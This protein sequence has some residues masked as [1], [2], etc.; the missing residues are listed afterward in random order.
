MAKSVFQKGNKFGRPKGCQ[1]KAT[2]DIK[3][4]YKQLIENN[5]GNLTKWLEQ[6]G[7]NDPAKAIHILS[8]LSEYVIP[9]LARSDNTIQVTDKTGA[10]EDLKKYRASLQ[11][12]IDANK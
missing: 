6:I 3:E 11:K 2:V 8:D 12:E 7:N 4:A 10:I 5:L 1:N 9:K